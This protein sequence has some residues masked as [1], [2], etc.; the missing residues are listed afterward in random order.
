MLEGQKNRKKKGGRRRGD[1]EGKDKEKAFKVFI[2]LDFFFRCC[3][4][5]FSNFVKN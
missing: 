3:I 1:D 4:L 5:I 2:D